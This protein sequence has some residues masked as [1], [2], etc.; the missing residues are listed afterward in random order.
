MKKVESNLLNMALVMTVIAIVAGGLLVWVN[1]VTSGPIEQINKQVIE[2]GIKSVILSDSDMKFRVE[3]PYEKD[4][5]IFHSVYDMNDNLLGTA[6]E[7]TDKNAFGGDLKVMVGF[8]P[9]GEILGYEV[10]EH[11][12]TPGLGALAGEWFRQ[13]SSE[14]KQQ[15]AVATILLGAP[16]KPGNRNI[17]GMNPGDGYLTVSNDGGQIDAITASTITSRAFLN[18]VNSA[19]KALSDHIG[20]E[21]ESDTGVEADSDNDTVNGDGVGAADVGDGGFNAGAGSTGAE[22]INNASSRN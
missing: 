9:K 7:S 22:S 6:V 10:L 17:I 19:Y 3:K 13:E 16:V 5:F 12:E 2:N 14:I 8:D 21:T 1:N 4:G 15:S 20:I 11:S 18:A